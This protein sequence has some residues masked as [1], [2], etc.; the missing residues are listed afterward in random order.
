MDELTILRLA[1]PPARLDQHPAAVY[2]DRL[3]PG[4]CRT[5]TAALDTCARLL[6]GD[7]ATAEALPWEL[8]QYQHVQHLRTL[9][10]K[11]YA[12]A[13]ANKC[14]S[15]VRGVM[16]EAF[17][18]GLIDAEQYHRIKDIQGVRGSRLPKGR[19]LSAGEL[20]AL[21]RACTGKAGARDAAL[22][23]CL[24]ACGLRRSEAVGLDVSDYDTVSGALTVRHGKGRKE[25]IVYLTN[26]A[27]AAMTGW[28]E[29]R[30]SDPGPLFIRI[31]KGGHHMPDRRLTDQAVM[32][33]LAKRAGQAGVKKCSPHDLR[34]SMIGDLLDA[35]ADISTVSQ[36]AG[37]ASVTTTQRYDRR[38]EATKMRAAGM[39]H[40][41][42]V[43]Y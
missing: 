41:P 19:A 21:F 39:L 32:V 2:L 36:L 9:L 24:Y 16:R 29:V 4:S 12:P 31:L 27:R 22:L 40:I 33:V 20:A 10:E 15:A 30:G 23:A 7:T 3:A 18:L 17:H 35:G 14:L 38:G 26:G 37:H 8:L 34:R 1:L 6:A 11:Q 13:T 28:L 43:A 5:M 25:R 42:Y